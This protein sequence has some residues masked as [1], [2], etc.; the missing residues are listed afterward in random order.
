MLKLFVT[1]DIKTA[2]KGKFGLNIKKIKKH[3]MR[4]AV[5]IPK[6]ENEKTLIFV[7]SRVDLLQLICYNNSV[8]MNQNEKGVK[9]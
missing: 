5:H 7:T 8:S 1:R 3:I 2:S 6:T 4:G 9:I